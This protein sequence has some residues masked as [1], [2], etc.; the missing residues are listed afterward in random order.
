MPTILL[1]ED[2]E[3]NRDMLARRLTRRDYEVVVAVDGLAG[4]AMA[5]SAQRAG[6]PTEAREHVTAATDMYREMDM[7]FWLEKAEA[8]WSA[9][10]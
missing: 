5:R 2:D 7:P 6:R 8:A 9:L 4:L 3:L 10:R 1:V